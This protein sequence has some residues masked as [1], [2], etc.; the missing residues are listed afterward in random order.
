MI[1]Y[2]FYGFV[3]QGFYSC[4]NMKCNVKSLENVKKH[5]SNQKIYDIV[6]ANK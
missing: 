4:R 2:E 1:H 5:F 3:G 6:I